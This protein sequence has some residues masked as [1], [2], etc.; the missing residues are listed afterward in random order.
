M[1][2]GLEYPRI[3]QVLGRLTMRGVMYNVIMGLGKN[4]VV[5]YFEA[6]IPDDEA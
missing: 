2:D 3:K 4:F 5:A 1:E 6:S